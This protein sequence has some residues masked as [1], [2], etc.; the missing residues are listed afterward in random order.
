MQNLLLHVGRLGYLP[1]LV[2]RHDDTIPIVVFDI[3]K[4]LHPVFEFKILFRRIKNLRVRVCRAVA[5]GNLCDI[6]FQPDNHRLVCQSQPLHFLRSKAHYQRFARPN[7]V[8]AYPASVLFEH[9]DTI[10]L[11]LVNLLD[12]VLLFQRFQVQT[13]KTLV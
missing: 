12:I 1:E 9:P 3:V 5:L 6:G 4:E 7:L 2:V 10:L 8:V 13:R 11:A